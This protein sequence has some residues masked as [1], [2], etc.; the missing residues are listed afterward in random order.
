MRTRFSTNQWIRLIVSLAVPLIVGAIGGLAT[1]SSLTDWYPTLNKPGWTPP[2]WLFA[3]VWTALYLAMGLAAWRV[4][5]RGS[6]HRSVRTG[7]ALFAV[8]LILNLG[9][10]LIFFGLQRT[11]L[12]LVDIFLL[13]VVLT[14]MLVAFLRIDRA[15][16]LLIAPYLLWSWFA[17]ALN[18]SI[19]W[20]N[21]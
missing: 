8:Q 6:E 14:V 2:D 15:A 13:D 3:P 17:T 4:W 16:G 18:A 11:G 5:N 9:W 1:T 12:A 21:R 20:L 7:L 10:S 19:W